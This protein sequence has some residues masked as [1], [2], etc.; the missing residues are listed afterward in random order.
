[1]KERFNKLY[2]AFVTLRNIIHKG[3]AYDFSDLN[4]KHQEEILNLLVE[5]SSYADSG[6][7][8]CIYIIK[9][10]ENQE[11]INQLYNTIT[12]VIY[13]EHDLF[14]RKL[15]WNY[16]THVRYRRRNRRIRKELKKRNQP[17]HA[18]K[19]LFYEDW[20]EIKYK[21]IRK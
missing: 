9:T 15:Y 2:N 8:L 12:E 17:E 6:L 1:M 3:A 13:Y 5:N 16:F 11:E 7:S 14:R 21:R 4:T 10:S 19:Q 18:E 20:E